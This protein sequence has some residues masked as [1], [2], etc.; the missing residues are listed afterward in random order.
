MKNEKL[1]S[2][3]E[4]CTSHAIEFSFMRNLEDFGLIEI[5]VQKDARYIP[6][7]QL[8]KLEHIL[9]LN[10]DLDI[11]L[12]GIDTIDHLLQQVKDLQTE[13]ARLRSR[14]CLYEDI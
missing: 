14:L 13:I 2:V 12:E 3:D 11:N 9:R 8:G 10:Q 7:S 6:E 5:V 1:I 4:F